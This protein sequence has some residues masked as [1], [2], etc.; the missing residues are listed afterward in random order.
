MTTRIFAIHG[1]YS[2]PRIFNY[3]KYKLGDEYSWTFLNYQ[4]QIDDL[5]KIIKSVSDLK[6]PHHIIGH[7]MGGLIGLKLIDKSWVDSITTI[8]TP[9]G[10][11]D[12]SI[13]QRYLSRSSFLNDI[14]DY[15]E[16]IRS[17][18]QTKTSKPI[19]HLIST[20][21][22]N[23]FILE[24]SDGVITLRSQQSNTLGPIYKIPATHIGIMLSDKIRD[25]LVN[26]WTSIL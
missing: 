21:G 24:N 13:M 11:I 3:L 22:F 16:F 5:E 14:A 8:S 7:S 20:T 6:E 18:K 25:L 2:T 9:L 15:S 17:I 10:G 19:Q 12:I 1:A 26:F 23:P 4:V